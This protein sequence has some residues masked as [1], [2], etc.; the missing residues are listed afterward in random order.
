MENRRKNFNEQKQKFL[1]F[2]EQNLDKQK[3]IDHFSN[4]KDGLKIN[5]SDFHVT[6]EVYLES[7][8]EYFGEDFCNFKIE[9]ENNT[10]YI[11]DDV[12]IL[13]GPASGT[14]YLRSSNNVVL[15]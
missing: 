10:I 2:L 12:H 9:P 14:Y 15:T 3:M 7:M 6:K 8:K 4:S 13:I 1:L 5:P 11:K